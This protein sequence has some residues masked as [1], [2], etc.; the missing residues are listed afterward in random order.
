MLVGALRGCETDTYIYA[1]L[2]PEYFVFVLFISTFFLI[3]QIAKVERALLSIGYFFTFQLIAHKLSSCTSSID[4]SQFR[5]VVHPKM[6]V[7][8]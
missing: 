8:L 1:L 5:G 2:E 3:A 4:S 7:D 6:K